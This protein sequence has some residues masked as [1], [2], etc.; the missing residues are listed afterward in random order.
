M[1]LLIASFVTTLLASVIAVVLC[2]AELGG[3]FAVIY[4]AMLLSPVFAATREFNLL[5]PL[6][7]FIGVAVGSLILLAR[8]IVDAGQYGQLIVLLASVTF[9]L[10]AITQLMTAV[11]IEPTLASG[12]TILLA[13]AWLS[14]PIWLSSSMTDSIATTLSPLHPFL[15]ING[16]VPQYGYWHQARLMYS[17]TN[18]GQDVN[19]TF[20][21]SVSA[22]SIFHGAIAIGG[23]IPLAA[24]R[25]VQSRRGTSAASA[26]APSPAA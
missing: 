17:L 1:K 22:A 25:V 5:P 24:W 23:I 11:R 8:E 26:S 9:A 18:L 15:A 3:V 20:P 13:I 19:F 12:V 16:A 6:G 2:G 7:V 4:V 21:T 14:W 10:A